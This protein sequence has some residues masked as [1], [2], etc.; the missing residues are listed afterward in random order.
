MDPMVSRWFRSK[1]G[2]VTEAQSM[3]VP[4]IHE[5]RSVLVSSPTGSGKTLTAF[6]SII[7]ELLLLA[8]EGRL[9]DRIYAVYISPLKALAND[10]NENL[11]RPLEE[12]S[13][14]Y[15]NEGLPRPG[16]RVA[17]RTGDTLPS[18]R[19]R[20][21][22]TPPHIFIT[23]PESLSLVLSTPVFR[24]KFESVD[25]VI[26][27]EVHDICDSKRGVALSVALERLQSFCPAELTRIGLSATVAPVEQVAEFLG[28]CRDGRPR[29]VSV[30]EV[31]GQR[32]LDLMVLC[33]AEDM[34]ALS[35]EVVN[36]K[37]YDLLS[38]MINHHRTTLV[39]TNTRSGTE[40]VVYKLKERG[41][42]RIGA[43][44]G[45]LS[46]ETRLEVEESLREGQLKAAVSSTSLELGID[47]GSIDLVVQIGSPKSVAKGLQRV[48]RSG[49]QYRG[50]SRGRILVFEPDDLVECAVLCRAA[51]EKLVDRV[52][53]PANSLDV[54]SQ[55]L[56]GMSI[57]RK[58][59]VDDALA[60]LRGSYCYRDLTIG[61]LESVLRFLGGK[62]EFEGVYSKLWYDEQEKTFGRKRG[63]R[64]IFYLNQGTI[65]EEAD[66]K[67]YSERGSLVGSLSEKFVERLSQGD[68]FVLGGRTYEFIKTK[69]TKAFVKSASG[70]KPTVPSWTGEM[71]P[72]SFDLSVLIGGFRE[73][74]ERR[75]ASSTTGEVCSWLMEEYDVDEG[76]ATTIVNYFKEQEAVARIPTDSRL[77]VE[78]YADATGKKNAVFH[79]PFGRRV[80]D[81][82]SRAFALVLSERLNCNVTISV[83]DDNFMLTA[84]KSFRLEDLGGMVRSK[85][86]PDILRRAVRD[87]ELFAQRFRHVATRSF[88]VL[89][90]YKGKE[91]SV[92]RQQLRSRRLLDAL[93]ELEDFPV[94][95]ETYT[96]ILTDVMDLEHA[97][98][99]LES[100]EQG[101]RK[102]EYLPFS[103]VPS[104]FAHNVVLVGVSDI[105]LLEDKS[106]LLRELH[107][108]VLARALGDSAVAK[109]MFDAEKVEE[110]FSAKAPHI[111]SKG[112]IL[113]ALRKM[114]P[115]NIFREKGE[116]IYA[117]SP[118]SFDTLRTWAAELLRD[119]KV[120]SVWVGEDM[121]VAAEDYA[122]YASMRVKDLP[123]DEV[124]L[125]LLDLAGARPRSTVELAEETGLTRDEARDHI[126]RLE[127][128]HAL[129]RTSIRGD[130]FL[131]SKSSFE[132]LPKDRCVSGAV[133][134]HLAYH[135]PLTVED[136][137]FEVGIPEDEAECALRALVASETVV[138]GMFIIG[139]KQQYMLARDFLALQAHGQPVFERET[140][141]AHRERKQF[142]RIGSVREFFERFGE[143]G[144]MYDLFQRVEG[145]D[146]EE[147]ARMRRSGEL[148]LGR[149]V[150]GRVRYV[151][152][153]DAPYYL[154]A[155]RRERLNKYE[156]AILRTIEKT[157]SGTYHAIAE[158]AGMPQGMMRENFDSLDRKG[159]LVRLYTE[160]ESWSSR[161]VY[162][163]C[164]ADPR[165]KGAYNRVLER[166]LRAF[167]PVTT[168][169]AASYLDVQT[170]QAAKLLRAVGAKPIT[171]GLE[172]TE[173]Y[174]LPD[175]LDELSRA[176]EAPLEEP[177]VRI[178][179]LYDPF[180]ADRWT[181]ISSRYGEAWVYPVVHRSQIV[182][183]VEKWLMA[184]SVEIREVQLDDPSLLGRLVDAIDAMMP[185]YNMLG[186]DIVRVRSVFGTEVTDL[187]EGLAGE[188]LSRG[189]AE[190]NGMFVK[191][192]L[193][194]ECF[195][196][197]EVLGAVLAQQNLDDPSHLENTLDVV[198]QHGG[199]RSNPAAIVRAKSFSSLEELQRRGTLVRGHVIPEGVGYCTEEQAGLYA[200][201]RL[202]DLSDEERL[203]LR[204][205]KDQQPVRRERL[206]TLSPL[207]EQATSEAL[208]SLYAGSQVFLDG[209][210]S[211]VAPPRRR[212]TRQKAWKRVV[213]RLF[214][215]YGI[216][217]AES[218]GVLIGHEIPMREVRA[219][220]R[221]LE[222]DGVLV[223]GFLLNGSSTLY[224]CRSDLYPSLGQGGF[225]GSVVLPPNDD[226]VL[227]LR[228]SFRNLLPET[229]RYVIFSG[230]SLI[231]SFKA[232]RREGKFEVSDLQG[233]PGV[234]E[235]AAEFSKRIGLAL[236]AKDVGRI[237]EWEI[238]DFYHR[239][240]PGLRARE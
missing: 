72:R 52:T 119:G 86:L 12:I 34:T 179:S 95:D 220:L 180:L 239:S 130:T 175:E 90:N 59:S 46:R 15:E 235:L 71:L 150:R 214:E 227:Y 9:E 197:A 238:A 92:A 135:G 106:M 89:R 91:L 234:A 169:Q 232:R 98:D 80:N 61:Q 110:Y 224:W 109:H 140:A 105:V 100:I 1:F 185:F 19:Q 127:V 2:A 113:D 99:V 5:R 117:H 188:F 198:S 51:H 215:R 228:A 212:M 22:R 41:V 58:W 151:L 85:D 217:S 7:N 28:G 206:L 10:I 210:Q 158:A 170:E 104:P 181:E 200:A 229:G 202:Q 8:R 48:G 133:T 125:R 148:L 126:R 184:G 163:P 209:V 44:H 195:D 122:L 222:H 94:M 42:D 174:V 13:S 14:L 57:E 96:E 115:M 199:L 54:L 66:Y 36:S 194:T 191:G 6:L 137:A 79:F 226:V 102:V 141:R 225:A 24:K 97:T 31:L 81:A 11:L 129:T 53:M 237:S 37:M 231:G 26:V 83:T 116:S 67:V 118:R 39:F 139:E 121:Y 187:D 33:P 189:Y 213:Q 75:L 84:P 145:F 190:S 136:L 64:M 88:M 178:L 149:F 124:A 218:L 152:A 157:G 21:A 30:V 38:D 20:Q 60:L 160:S 65:P 120:R 176:D 18:E 219:A 93:H 111:E 155:Y 25:Y 177:G 156:A 165:A 164:E 69:A 203:V 240:H 87:S 56:V 82:L 131:F 193:V 35:F 50:T 40:S 233:E 74:M 146:L 207:G 172:R 23:T 45:S 103:S 143:A 49:H 47:I 171:V 230:S 236:A 144:M 223:K 161:N 168:F 107:R 142:A 55:A 27:D 16:I 162:A 154:G 73:E 196:Q 134:R 205:V 29:S 68:I 108:R 17:V 183:M 32:D 204:I 192:R 167:G 4:L 76:S 186:V 112:D 3:A 70:R 216:I 211:Y 201:A 153:Q 132:P 63:G 166:F 62:D 101:K 77:L 138:T 147:F 43:H 208:K 128:A 123:D 114:G 173:M 221:S 159:Y 78:G 182:G